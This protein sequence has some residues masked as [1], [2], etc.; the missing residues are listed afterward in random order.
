MKQIV[1]DYFNKFQCIAGA[2]RH[3]C[4]VGWEID[5]D[6]DALDHY[7]NVSGAFSRRLSASIATDG[8]TAHFILDENERCPFLNSDGLCDLIIEL[9]EDQLCN[10]CADHPRFRNYFSDRTEIG[11]GLCCEA[12]AGLILTQ[13]APAR[14]TVLQDDGGSENLSEEEADLIRLRDELFAIAQNRSLPFQA[15]MRQVME[16]CDLTLPEKTPRGWAQFYLSLERLDPVW[17][18]LLECLACA[19]FELPELPQEFDIALEQLFVYFLYRHIPG[20]MED[21]NIAG[22]IAFAA[23]SCRMIGWLCAAHAGEN[24]EVTMEEFI[25]TARMYSSEIEYSDENL[26]LL[27]ELPFDL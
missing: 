6:E 19:E 20:A 22:R 21:D 26:A 18:R 5:I 11:L 4:C 12:A 27:F 1:P 2:C 25:E 3:S 13:D 9:G 7:Q 14:L 16:E 24:G 10:I 15:R 23:I 17:T 8:E